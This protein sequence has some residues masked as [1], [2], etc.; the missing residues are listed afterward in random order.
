MSRP[1]PST[2]R[3]RETPDAA[4][5]GARTLD[6]EYVV[7]QG[8]KRPGAARARP[9]KPLLKRIKWWANAIAIAAIVGF[10]IPPA[11]LLARALLSN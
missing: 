9:K 7:V 8:P 5:A 4:P 2:E 11:Y 3:L 10:L 1:H 6:A